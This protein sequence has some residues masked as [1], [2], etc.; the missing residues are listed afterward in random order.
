MIEVKENRY[1]L[2]VWFVESKPKGNVLLTAYK[3][4]D[5]VWEGRA[6]IRT[7]VDDKAFDSEDNKAVFAFTDFDNQYTEEMV[8]GMIQNLAER[9]SKVPPGDGKVDFVP[10]YTNDVTKIM[11]NLAM[12]EWCHMKEEPKEETR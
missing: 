8:F 12:K 7:Y 9:I 5:G 11:F 6:R 1:F 4:K 2:G 3:D 10:L